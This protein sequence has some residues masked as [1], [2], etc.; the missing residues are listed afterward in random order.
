MGYFEDGDIPL[1][2]SVDVDILIHREIHFGGSFA[3]MLDYYE[4]DGIGV[5]PDFSIKRIQLLM[6]EEE[7]TGKNLA[8]TLLTSSALATVEDAKTMYL[9]LRAVYEHPTSP[10][11]SL[12][13]A[14]LI[15][16]EEENPQEEIDAV[17]RHESAAVGPLVEIL[18]TEKLYSSLYPGYGRAPLLAAQCLET[19]GDPKA[20][21]PLFEALGKENFFADDAMISALVSFGKEAIDFLLVRLSHKPFN[22]DNEHAA[23]A[24]SSFPEEYRVSKLCLHLLQDPD[25]KKHPTLANYLILG[26]SAL[27][28]QEEKQQFLKLKELFPGVIKHEF[29]LIA[30]QWLSP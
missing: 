6:E 22:K 11:L 21:A 28:T 13:M 25:I 23:I 3:L 8:D 17:C 7:K 27:K 30:K 4:H 29:D 15:L 1:L 14:D 9:N 19:I 18:S 10:A 24:L 5:N 26:C 2:D 16:S 12:V 20:I